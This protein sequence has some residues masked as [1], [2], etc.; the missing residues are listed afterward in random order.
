MMAKQKEIVVQKMESVFHE[1]DCA[2]IPTNFEKFKEFWMGI[3]DR[4]PREFRHSTEVFI[5]TSE[6]YGDTELNVQ[7]VYS[8]PETFQ[9]KADRLAKVDSHSD[10]MKKHEIGQLKML[11]KKYPWIK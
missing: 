1:E 5:D 6:S 4:V 8:R 7:V 11:M 3:A 10:K 2:S 9:E